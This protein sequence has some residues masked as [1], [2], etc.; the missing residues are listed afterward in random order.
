MSTPDTE[1]FQSGIKRALKDGDYELASELI[2]QGNKY[3]PG[4]RQRITQEMIMRSGFDYL[5][6]HKATAPPQPPKDVQ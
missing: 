1:P 3:K 6:S 4:P 5:P 2:E